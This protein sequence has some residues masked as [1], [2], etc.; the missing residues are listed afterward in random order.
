M[1]AKAIFSLWYT[2]C[3]ALTAAVHAQHGTLF[4]NASLSNMA[5]IILLRWHDATASFLKP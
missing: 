2:Y 3:I 5:I 1:G 4:L